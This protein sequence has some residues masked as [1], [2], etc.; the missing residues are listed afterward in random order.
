M[1][2]DGLSD[3]SLDDQLGHHLLEDVLLLEIGI[4]TDDRAS[5]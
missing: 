4:A 5:S 1:D 3:P 2:A